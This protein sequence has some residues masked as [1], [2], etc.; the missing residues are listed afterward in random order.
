MG[1][2]HDGGP[3]GLLGRL[4][5]LE[6]LRLDGDV[7]GRGRLVG[8]DDVGVVGDG[9]GDHH[10]LAHAAGELVREPP[11]SLL[12]VGDADEFE[13]LDGPPGRLVLPDVAVDADRLGDLVAHGVD[14][15]EGGERVLEDHRDALAPQ[16][17]ELPVAHAPQLLALE[18]DRAGN[19]GARGQETHHRQR[20]DGLAGAGLADDAEHLAGGDGVAQ[21]PHGRDRA[22]SRW[23]TT[24]GGPATSS[25]A[26]GVAA[27]TRPVGVSAGRSKLT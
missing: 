11:G 16:R 1:D 7:E 3:G 23:G 5:H 19:V 2:H 26:P 9:H 22:G 14:G 27:A 4:E 17:G 21:A 6:D 20:G 24:R 10:P 15:R 18:A 12:G 25:T 13:Q 8:D